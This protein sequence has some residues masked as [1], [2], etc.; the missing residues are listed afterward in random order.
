MWLYAA[1][2]LCYKISVKITK[3]ELSGDNFFKTFNNKLYINQGILENPAKRW[4]DILMIR[5][6]DDEEEI[7]REGQWATDNG[8]KEVFT[9]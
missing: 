6:G 1:Q 4:C 9:L 2:I 7:R 3:L 5:R 8:N